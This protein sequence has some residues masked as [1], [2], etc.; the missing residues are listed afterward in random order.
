[1]E[2]QSALRN[3]GLAKKMASLFGAS[4]ETVKVE[5]LFTSEVMTF[6]RKIENAHQKA[7]DSKL[8]FG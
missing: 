3:A 5:M 8:V 1:M 6:I 7:A 2:K 4:R